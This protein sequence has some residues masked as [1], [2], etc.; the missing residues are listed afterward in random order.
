VIA[1]DCQYLTHLDGRVKADFGMG[2]FPADHIN[3]QAQMAW[4]FTAP[5]QPINSF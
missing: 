1:P 4:A 5:D 2:D 3:H